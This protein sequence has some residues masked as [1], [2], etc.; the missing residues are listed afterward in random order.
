[1]K[2][3]FAKTIISMAAISAFAIV[4]AAYADQRYDI[5]KQRDIAKYSKQNADLDRADTITKITHANIEI[6]IIH[7][8]NQIPLLTS[9]KAD[10]IVADF[11]ATKEQA[12][13]VDF[14]VPYRDFKE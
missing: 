5:K 14:N 8:I 7:S 2:F 11:T 6:I 13:E 1:M 3:V 10:F 12:K 4:N 9:Q